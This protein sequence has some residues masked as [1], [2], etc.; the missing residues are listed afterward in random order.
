MAIQTATR[1]RAEG[2]LMSTGKTSWRVTVKMLREYSATIEV[3]ARSQEEADEAALDAFEKV[4]CEE[5]LGGCDLGLPPP[6]N[7]HE[8]TDRDPK[9]CRLFRCVDCAK[10]TSNSGEYYSVSKEVWAASGLAPDG[11]MLCLRCLEK[12]IGREL[13]GEDFTAMWPNPDAWERHLA[14]RAQLSFFDVE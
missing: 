5:G 9:I 1:A 14:A 6:W 3:R 12:R 7:E 2:R 11:G 13:N 8:S 10:D 4:A